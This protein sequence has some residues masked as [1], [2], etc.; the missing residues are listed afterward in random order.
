MKN[1]F[2]LILLALPISLTGLI[3][4]Q[5]CDYFVRISFTDKGGIS[6][7]EF[8]LTD[9]F[10]VR[11]VERRGKSGSDVVDFFDLPLFKPYIDQIIDSGLIYHSSSRWMNSALFCTSIP[12]DTIRI[13]PLG[14][15]KEIRIVKEPPL[16][17]K[18]NKLALNESYGIFPNS[19]PLDQLNGIPFH[20][21]GYTGKGILIAVL[22]AGF[23]NTPTVSSLQHLFDRNAI[24]YTLNILDGSPNVYAFHQHG[25]AVLTSLAGDIPGQLRGTGPGA[26][27]LLFRSED[28]ASEYPVEEDYWVVAA[29]KADSIG[30]DIISSS[31]GYTQFDNPAMDYS[32][33]D[34]DGNTAYITKAAN[35]AHSRNILVVNSAGNS[36]N[37]S[38]K[39][40]ITPSDGTGV[41]AIGAIDESG[42]I[43]TFSSAGPAYDKRVKPDVVAAG[44]GVPAQTSIAI[45]YLNGTSFS[46]PVISG[47][48]ACL[49]QAS[50]NSTAEDIMIAIRKSADRFNTPDTLYGFGLPDFTR[51]FLLLS[52]SFNSEDQNI[53]ALPNPASDHLYLNF[54]TIPGTLDINVYTSSGMKVYTTKI[55]N[56][57]SNYLELEQFHRFPDGL[58]LI[59]IIT[60]GER[61]TLKVIKYSL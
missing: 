25:T 24:K 26:D 20:D 8:E 36:R 15:I 39:Y 35:I 57:T 53:I 38:W 9:L 4:Q 22:D 10:S 2:L 48:A 12:N 19:W 55:N 5:P 21:E 18:N 11:A 51:T 41:L 32:Y 40:L 7:N 3:A 14:F 27:F 29:E 23:E 37:E 45:R 52:D 44:V 46:C 59:E 13:S 33:S 34:L 6:E 28:G 50:P 47:M 60:P 56:H 17:K 58:L 49:M 43:S 61:K 42:T 16:K 1:I 54:R 31:L 30:A